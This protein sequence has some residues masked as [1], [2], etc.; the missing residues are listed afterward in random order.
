MGIST[1]ISYTANL[2][3]VKLDVHLS[4]SRKAKCYKSNFSLFKLLNI[5]F[6]HRYQGRKLATFL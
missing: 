5:G 1:R 2:G 4:Y 6:D 3:K